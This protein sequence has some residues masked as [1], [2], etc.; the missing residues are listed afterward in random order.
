MK[1]KNKLER[2]GA[3]VI[4]LISVI[5]FFGLILSGCQNNP[6]TND[7]ISGSENVDLSFKAEQSSGDNSSGMVTIESAKILLK[8]V[9]FKQANDPDVDVKV[10]PF[11]VQLNL[12]GIVNTVAVGSV[13]P[14][15]YN[16]VKFVI[17]KPEDFETPPDPDFKTGTS[18][19]SRFSFIIKGTYNGNSFTYKSR[20]SMSQEITF[21]SPLNIS[22][23][24]KVNVTFLVNMSDWFIK[25][26]VELDPTN[27]N[28][29]NDIDKN[30]KESF[31]RAFKDNNKNGSPDD[32]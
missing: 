17:H 14:G 23:D 30:I 22:N 26:G 27:E 28:N 3:I 13:P 25:N 5:L 16:R 19:N 2:T 6:V 31:K 21:P 11:V 12:D 10:G 8:K 29:W 20:K 18:G 1:T 32:N 4:G 9:Q 15:I 7:P 24:T